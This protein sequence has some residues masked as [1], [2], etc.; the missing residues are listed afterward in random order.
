[1]SNDDNNSV[2]FFFT[3]CSEGKDMLQ[4]MKNIIEGL[5]A[6][7]LLNISLVC[8]IKNM[9]TLA[10]EGKIIVVNP[11]DGKKDKALDMIMSTNPILN[12][13]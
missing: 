5:D 3:H 9:R 7:E 11:L 2:S 1:M 13:S 6:N 12:P 8:N 10:N 4:L